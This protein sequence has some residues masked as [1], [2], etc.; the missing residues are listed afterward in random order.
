MGT[1]DDNDVVFERN[2]ERA[3]FLD[4]FSSTATTPV[5]GNTSWGVGALLGGSHSA[6]YTNNTAIGYYAL[7]ADPPLLPPNHPGSCNTAVG[8]FA[9]YNNQ[10]LQYSTAIGFQALLNQTLTTGGPTVISAD[11][12]AVGSNALYNNVV[13]S[14]YPNPN[15]GIQ[16]TAV[17]D[18]ALLSVGSTVGTDIMYGSDNTAIGYDA[19]VDVT[20]GPVYG[21]TAI[22]AN[23]IVSEPDALVLGGID[24]VDGL[25]PMVGIGTPAPN[26]ALDVRGDVSCSGST[27]HWSDARYKDIVD[28]LTQSQ[29]FKIT[30]QI[31]PV[32]FHWDIAALAAK[33]Y[34]NKNTAMQLGFIAQNVLASGLPEIVSTGD[35]NMYS[36][37]Y[38]K[39]TPLLLADA[40]ELIKRDSIKGSQI[41]KLMASNDSLKQVITI[42]KTKQD[43]INTAIQSQINQCCSNNNS[44]ARIVAP[45]SSNL[46]AD[47]NVNL[48][49]EDVIYQNK[50]NPFTSETEINYS[51][52]TENLSVIFRDEF[53]SELQIVAVPVGQG[54]I[55]VSSTELAAGIYTYSLADQTG[56]VIQTRKM[57]K[58]K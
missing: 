53:G 8:S 25:Y 39:I 16:N 27:L 20:N 41:Q 14:G 4:D 30:S 35:T 2:Y 44:N 42:Y 31:V 26:Y 55:K 52:K 12:V 47:I 48:H 19:D 10:Y 45:D 40:K 49:S 11:N 46:N 51:V 33:G 6:T 38:G 43:S 21:S 15:D 37:D 22:G 32:Y 34:Y 57:L 17:G 5:S 9:L 50:P 54:T 1:L 36:L 29:A 3:G 28:T 24:Q 7:C 58:S 56:R 23:A 13:Y 18:N